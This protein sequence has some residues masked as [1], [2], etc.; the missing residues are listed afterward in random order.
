M[1]DDGRFDRLL[2][3]VLA[4]W[5]TVAP[6]RL[7][8]SILS[9]VHRPQRSRHLFIPVWRRPASH[10][11]WL[12]LAAGLTL[13]LVVGVVASDRFAAR[14]GTSGPAATASPTPSMPPAPTAVSGF[15][16][17]GQT[18]PLAAGRHQM[19]EP[20]TDGAGTWPVERLI[21]KVPEGWTQVSPLRGGGLRKGD[22][23]TT[24]A[25]LAFG[26]VGQPLWGPEDC[27]HPEFWLG[28]STNDL[29]SMV[30]G[31]VDVT[32]ADVSIGRYT[33][34]R[35]EITLD[36]PCLAIH[37]WKTPFGGEAWEY[38]WSQG[39]HH[40]LS[41]LDI[42]GVRFVIDASYRLDASPELVAE[43]QSIVDSIELEP[44]SR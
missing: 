18:G 25:R 40:Q 17:S 31:L 3:D 21:L 5:P 42:E 6:D 10:R 37:G 19:P 8:A 7:A 13:V 22:P 26:R 32:V 39:W 43:V 24:S 14:P 4:D 16:G 11:S 30:E 35:M 28:P 2:A 27:S 9:G 23:E 33:G 29:V 1:T 34:E 20:N 15:I 12:S 44:R 36:D 41:I 38:D